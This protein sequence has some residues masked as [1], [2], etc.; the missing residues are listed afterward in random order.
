MRAKIPRDQR[1]LARHARGQGWQLDLRGSG[2][3]A[4]RSPSGAV[5]ITSATPSDWRVLR[6]LRAALR[7][8]GLA[9]D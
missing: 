3:V 4:W 8:H 2:H 7:R 6:K 5:L 9:L 1:A